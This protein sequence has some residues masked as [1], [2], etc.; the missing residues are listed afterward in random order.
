MVPNSDQKTRAIAQDWTSSDRAAPWLDDFTAVDGILF[1]G[2]VSLGNEYA[3]RA[4]LFPNPQRCLPESL[5][6][7]NGHT[8]E[9][10]C[11]AKA[12]GGSPRQ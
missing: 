10:R 8:S 7:L 5:A 2:D 11:T 9:E 4:R 12:T 1:V 3:A 6:T